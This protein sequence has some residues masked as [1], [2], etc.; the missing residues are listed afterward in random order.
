ME[1][2]S[3]ERLEVQKYIIQ[4]KYSRYREIYLLSVTS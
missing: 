4:A 1:L 3:N 2:V